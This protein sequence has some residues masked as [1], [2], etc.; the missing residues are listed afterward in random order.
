MLIKY[1]SSIKI[2]VLWQI[3]PLKST[4]TVYLALFGPLIAKYSLKKKNIFSKTLIKFGY[5]SCYTLTD[6]AKICYTLRRLPP[7]INITIWPHLYAVPLSVA[8]YIH[9]TLVL[10][11]ILQLYW[12]FFYH[13]RGVVN[14]FRNFERTEHFVSSLK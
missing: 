3:L 13:L 11:T 2:G 5:I 9:L 6:D 4:R 7:L 12:A 14:Y 1:K 8:L 10:L